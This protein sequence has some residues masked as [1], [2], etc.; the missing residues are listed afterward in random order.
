[1]DL[2]K[3]KKIEESSKCG[4]NIVKFQLHIPDFEMLKNAP[5]PSI[6]KVKIGI[7]IL[8]EQTLV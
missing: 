3:R 7:I 1:M 2:W 8:K 5:S 4:A 6:L